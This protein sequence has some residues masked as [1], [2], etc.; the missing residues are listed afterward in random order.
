MLATSA[1]RQGVQRQDGGQQRE[2]RDA[3]LRGKKRA[4]ALD[5]SHDAA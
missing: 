3:R 5:T 4:A 2:E 1:S